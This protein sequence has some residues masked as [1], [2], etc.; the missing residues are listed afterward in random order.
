MISKLIDLELVV[1]ELSM[2]KVCGIIEISKIEFFN[3]SSTERVQLKVRVKQ[4]KVLAS[5]LSGL[6]SKGF[7]IFTGL[8]E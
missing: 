2:F 8:Q 7:Q 4:I 6:R 3:F 1:L 5:Q